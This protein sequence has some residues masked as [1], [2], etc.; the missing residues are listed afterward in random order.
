M[1]QCTHM[2]ATTCFGNEVYVRKDALYFVLCEKLYIFIP[3]LFKYV[4]ARQNLSY[5]IIIHNHLL[6]IHNHFYNMYMYLILEMS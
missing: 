1:S 3:Y 4:S 6:K 2:S 5:D